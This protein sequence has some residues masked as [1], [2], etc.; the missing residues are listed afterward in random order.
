[1]E[2]EDTPLDMLVFC[3][4]I[5]SRLNTTNVKLLMLQLQHTA[6]T[7]NSKYNMSICIQGTFQD[8]L[9]KDYIEFEFT[10]FTSAPQKLF[11]W[12]KIFNLSLTKQH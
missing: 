9:N 8:F 5:P 1:M 3:E 7:F 12:E 11:F 6:Y 2:R 10:E 4:H